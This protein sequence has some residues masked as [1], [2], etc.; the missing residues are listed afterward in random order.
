VL[1]L[2]GTPLPPVD[3]SAV[4][5]QARAKFG[6]G[7]VAELPKLLRSTAVLEDDLVDLEGI[8]L[9]G[10]KAVNTV[11]YSLDEFG[12]TSLVILVNQLARGP[13][14]RLVGHT[15]EA[16]NTTIVERYSSAMTST[17]QIRA[18]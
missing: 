8:E 14:L 4:T 5:N 18:R 11:A 13:S 2:R 9:T 17:R 3:D 12:Q 1:R 7:E 6:V 16:T 15:S 10:T